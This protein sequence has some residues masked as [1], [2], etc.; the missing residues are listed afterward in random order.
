F[1]TA[2]NSHH[3][4]KGARYT[5]RTR[6]PGA[7]AIASA[8]TPATFASASTATLFG[9]RSTIYD[10]GT[11]NTMYTPLGVAYAK[12]ATVATSLGDDSTLHCGD[13]HTVGQWKPGVATNAA[14]D[15][16]TVAI[17]A[18]GSNNEYLLRN[19][20]G[21]D[22]RHT[23]SAYVVSAGTVTY[24]NSSQAYLVCFNCHA[25]TKYGSAFAGTGT[26]GTHAGEYDAGGRCNGAG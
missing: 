2:N 17:G 3:A 25:F 16:N 23:Q 6:T 18:H 12:P 7:R 14:G 10:A 21:T 26:A 22:A 20:Q 13:C 5:G 1:D 9:A 15:L 4:V 8:A 19:S 24:T 11:F